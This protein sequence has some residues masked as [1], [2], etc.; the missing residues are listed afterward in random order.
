MKYI[1]VVI[2]MLLVACPVTVCLTVIN[3]YV[4]D[5]NLGG[6]FRLIP[7]KGKLLNKFFFGNW[8]RNFFAS[9][10]AREI[11]LLVL[12]LVPLN[13]LM[14]IF[15]LT[16]LIMIIVALLR[17]DESSIMFIYKNVG[18]C[19]VMYSITLGIFTRIFTHLASELRIRKQ[20]KK[21]Q[22]GSLKDLNESMRKNHSIMWYYS[23]CKQLTNISCSSNDEIGEY[24][25]E[26]SQVPMITKL[27][28]KSSK[29]AIFDMRYQ[30]NGISEFIVKDRTNDNEVFKGLIRNK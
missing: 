21:E 10:G 18:F 30:K 4:V 27:V 6:I 23:L 2:G 16:Y 28:K 9:C 22:D 13:L 7:I 24:W 29:N 8:T 5:G 14:Y 17:G 12:I 3:Q 20:S 19:I 15:I 11:S 1:S 26:S 25:F